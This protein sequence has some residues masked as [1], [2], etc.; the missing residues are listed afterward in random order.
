MVQRNG[1]QN[2]KAAGSNPA[3]TSI[4]SMNNKKH[5]LNEEPIRKGV[6]HDYKKDLFYYFIKTT[7]P[8]LFII[9]IGIYLVSNL[10]FAALYYFSPNSIANASTNSFLDA[11]FFS[12]QTMATIGYGTLA[13]N[14][15]YANII[16]TLEAAFGII[17]VAIV[18]GFIFAK[19]SK[20]HAKILF[21]NNILQSK[22]DGEYCLCFRIGNARG[23]DIIEAKVSAMALINYETT[24]GQKIRK[25]VDLKLK[26]NQTPFFKLTWNVY[27]PLDQESPILIDG[28]LNPALIAIVVTVTG[29]DGTFSNTVYSR[30]NYLPQAIL[31]D[32]YFM[33]IMHE[34]ESGQ[35]LIDYV[36]FHSLKS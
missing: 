20:P 6:A 12:V 33:D 18:T 7:W 28:L 27:H 21:S 2:R 29:H 15:T 9:I 32:K 31:K 17:G 19:I 1:L 24:E 16:V 4:K 36:N 3:V 23:N 10:L 5:Y 35:M 30:H 22:F 8:R 13:P 25:V 26:R 11:F 34:L 14:N